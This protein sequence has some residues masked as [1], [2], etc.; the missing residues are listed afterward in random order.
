VCA[1]HLSIEID[2]ENEIVAYVIKREEM[3]IRERIRR[4][5]EKRRK[6]T[7]YS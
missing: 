4:I 3:R 6:N 5:E 2:S 7:N 1:V